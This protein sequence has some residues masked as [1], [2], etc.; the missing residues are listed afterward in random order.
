VGDGDKFQEKTSALRDAI[1]V[2]RSDGGA[3]FEG[4]KIGEAIR[5]K[6]FS[7]LVVA[8]CAS[9][10]AVAWLGGTHRF[11]AAGSQIGFHAAYDAQSGQERGYPNARVGAYLNRIGLTDDAVTYI[12]AAP[13]NSMTWL[14]VADAKQY[15]IDVTLLDVPDSF[16][17]T[18]AMARIG[19]TKET[20]APPKPNSRPLRTVE[21]LHLRTQPDP[22]APDAILELAPS[23]VIPKGMIV[24]V[25]VTDCTVWSGSGRSAQVANN[26]W[27][28]VDYGK[29]SGW[30][31][32]LTSSRQMT[33]SALP[34]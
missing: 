16:Y 12:T 28:A 11:M 1:V 13:P 21:D 14:S 4:I 18:Q 6:G 24:R 17:V 32:T 10:C 3:A 19:A 2:F 27:C 9:A 25:Y 8:R 20:V 23:D 5:Q 31:R 33:D 22:N 15:R 7:S 26:I 34:A 30:G 29:Y